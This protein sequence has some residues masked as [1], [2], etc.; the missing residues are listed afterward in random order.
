MVV[1]STRIA[2]YVTSQRST[3]NGDQ[4]EDKS[5][6]NSTTEVSFCTIIVRNIN[7]AETHFGGGVM[8]PF[9]FLLIATARSLL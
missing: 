2:T 3:S 4:Q 8:R 6:Q 7:C 5:T 1:T 9:V